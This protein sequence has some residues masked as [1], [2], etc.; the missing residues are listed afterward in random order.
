M[1]EKE[2]NYDTL[3]HWMCNNTNLCSE[4]LKETQSMSFNKEK[5]SAS[6]LHEDDSGKCM[7]EM[8]IR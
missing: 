8:I 4:K 2:D 3:M 7:V 6:M 1:N 5:L